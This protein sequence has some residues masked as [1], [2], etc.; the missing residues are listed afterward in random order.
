MTN[1]PEKFDQEYLKMF[2]EYDR[3]QGGGPVKTVSY[4]QGENAAIIEFVNASSVSEVLKK[5]PIKIMGTEVDIVEYDPYLSRGQNEPITSIKVE[6]VME[7][8]IKN[9]KMLKKRENDEL[10]QQREII[11]NLKGELK[12]KDEQLNK[13]L[14]EIKCRNDYI[15][16]L[17]DYLESIA[18]QNKWH[19]QNYD[20]YKR[21]FYKR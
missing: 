13:Q 11:S 12:D 7:S 3:G 10:K 17:K 1:I 9:L 15:S 19:A 4:D 16:R 2:F 18:E 8:M 6:G 20:C 21:Y 14:D 5:Q